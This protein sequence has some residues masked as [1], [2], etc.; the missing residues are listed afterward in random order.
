MTG[1][2]KITNPKGRVYIGQSIGIHARWEKDYKKLQCEK[3]V[4]LYNSLLKYG[5]SEHIFEVVEECSIEDLN[6][7]ERYWQDFY[8]VL[9]KKGL[10][11]KLT[12]TEDK[13][14][15]WS[16]ETKEKIGK[17][18]KGKLHTEA[19]KQQ[20][21]EARKGV[22]KTES[23]RQAISNTTKGRPKSAEH[24]QKIGDANR[25]REVTEEFRD[26]MSLIVSKYRNIEQYD[27]E[28]NLI[29]V[30]DTTSQASKQGFSKQGI[31]ECIK[32]I[33]RSHKGFIWKVCKII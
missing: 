22:L 4:R 27:F 28:G 5:F 20:M 25:G 18:R 32:G 17:A 21:S 2:Y 14:G 29:H 33:Q 11:C 26:K 13:S 16:E 9:S 31:V 7:R 12:K 23:H 8:D 30:Y 24:L 3:Q 10:N 6:T 19:T 1:I 15:K